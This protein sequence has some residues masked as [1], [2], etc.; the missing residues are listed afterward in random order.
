MGK[1]FKN[2]LEDGKVI[3]VKQFVGHAKNSQTQFHPVKNSQTKFYL[4]KMSQGGENPKCHFARAGKNSQTR[5]HLPK[6]SQSLRKISQ[7]S[8]AL[9]KPCEI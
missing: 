8:F 2:C 1:S 6:I 5:L 9:R 4:A 7:P 3:K